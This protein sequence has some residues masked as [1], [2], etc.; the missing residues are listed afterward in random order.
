MRFRLKA[1]VFTFLRK[2]DF[3]LADPTLRIGERT[4]YAFLLLNF[5]VLHWSANVI[6]FRSIVTRPYLVAEPEKGNQLP[7]RLKAL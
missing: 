1:I 6:K 4:A 3:E 7:L 5:L 2:I